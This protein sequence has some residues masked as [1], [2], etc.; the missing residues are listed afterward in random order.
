[1]DIFETALRIL[2]DILLIIVLMGMIYFAFVGLHAFSELD[3]QL[4]QIEQTQLYPSPG[5]NN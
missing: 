1:M 5:D 3:N 4:Q 2:R